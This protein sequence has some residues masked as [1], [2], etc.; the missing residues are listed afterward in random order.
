MVWIPG[1]EFW[2]GSDE[3]QFADA[4]PSHRVYV[5]GF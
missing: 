2:M 1:G 4:R 5:D 3:P